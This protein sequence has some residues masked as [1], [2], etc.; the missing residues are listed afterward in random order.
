M[1]IYHSE[2]VELEIQFYINIDLSMRPH[3]R[4]PKNKIRIL[5]HSIQ[6][7]IHKS[8]REVFGMPESL[9][10]WR[11][12]SLMDSLRPKIESYQIDSTQWLADIIVKQ[13]IPSVFKQIIYQ[14]NYDRPVD[15][16]NYFRSAKPLVI[17]YCKKDRKQEAISHFYYLNSMKESEF[18]I[19]FGNSLSNTYGTIF[20]LFDISQA[21]IDVEFE[22]FCYRNVALLDFNFYSASEFCGIDGFSQYIKTN[23]LGIGKKG[24][25]NYERI[26]FHVTSKET[27]NLQTVRLFFI[28]TVISILM[29]YIISCVYSIIKIKSRRFV[30]KLICESGTYFWA[31][32]DTYLDEFSRFSCHEQYLSKEICQFAI[33][34]NN[35]KHRAQFKRSLSKKSASNKD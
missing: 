2:D 20:R 15:T 6:D 31:V 7:S 18:D 5:S 13:S 24:I 12:Q 27:Q 8:S 33:E 17:D 34:Q 11:A 23:G 28:T 22:P 30:P 25:Y 32:Y 21:Y 9:T 29:T 10:Y 19:F 16:E 3:H 14:N 4:I 35:K 26:H 1:R